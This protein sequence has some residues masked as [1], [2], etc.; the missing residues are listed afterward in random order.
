MQSVKLVKVPKKK[1]LRTQVRANTKRIRQLKKGSETYQ[2][3]YNGGGPTATSVT[4][5]GSVFNLTLVAQGDGA[6]TR[7]G[8][9]TG[10]KRIRLRYD[11]IG[12]SLDNNSRIVRV[13][14]FKGKM[15]NGTLPVLTEILETVEPNAF[16]HNQYRHKFQILYDKRHVIGNRAITAA[17][18]SSGDTMV[19]GSANKKLSGRQYYNSGGASETNVSKNAIYLAILSDS[20]SNYPVMTWNSRYEYLP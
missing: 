1:T 10:H 6:G 5:T 19:I 16:Y 12:H 2:H 14:L 9:E 15:T 8:L 18:G 3:D 13:I 20:P 17:I 7:E 11:I 4:A